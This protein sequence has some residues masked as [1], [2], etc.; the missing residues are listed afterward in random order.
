MSDSDSDLGELC[1]GLD[2]KKL[3]SPNTNSDN[4]FEIDGLLSE[5]DNLNLISTNDQRME[6]MNAA[7]LDAVIAAAVTNALAAQKNDFERR[8]Q[9]ITSQIQAAGAPV[10]QVQSY[11]PITIDRRVACDE[12]LDAVKSLPEFHGSQE[13]YVSWRQAAKAAYT[14]YESFAGSSR[15]YQA[16]LIIRN[17]IRDS[18]DATLASFNTVLNFDAILSRLDFTYADKRPLHLLEQELATLRQGA[19]SVVQFYEEVEKKLTLLTNK[20]IMTHNGA[21]ATYLNE[22][23]RADALRVFISGL[24]KNLTDVLFSAQ[25]KD[26]PS[27][28]AMAQE[29]ESNHDRHNFAANYARALEEKAQKRSGD[30]HDSQR[31]QGR[32]PFYT[33]GNHTQQAGGNQKQQDQVEKME[34][35]PSLSK[36][37]QPTNYQRQQGTGQSAAATQSTQYQQGQYKRQHGSQRLSDQRRQRIN[38]LDEEHLEQ[39]DEDYEQ[40][41][42]EAVA[43]IDADSV[44]S[45]DSDAVNFLV[46]Y[47]CSRSS[48]EHSVTNK[49]PIDVVH[50]KYALSNEIRLRLL[51]TQQ[52]QLQRN[53]PARQNR[54]FDVGEKVLVKANRRK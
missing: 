5:F 22:K 47:P 40:T 31:G 4:E 38:H 8:L 26:L 6:N 10:P 29:I 14:I 13:Q 30:N 17:K 45:Y 28:L 18:A 7:Q 43:D 46:Q 20:T 16:V 25:P 15:H 11:S 33:R 51:K 19:S 39:S 12:S 2:I 48:S 36:F 54:T 21:Q 44:A 50:S 35:D 34:V 49:T 37:R 1:A 27:A 24:K 3:T 32:N 53:N 23:Y 42:T 52:E 41:A 9:E